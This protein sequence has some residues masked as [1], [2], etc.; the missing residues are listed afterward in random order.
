MYRDRLRRDEIEDSENTYL[1]EVLDKS[2]KST[3][4]GSE[5]FE[6]RQASAAAK[7]LRDMHIDDWLTGGNKLS[8]VKTMLQEDLE[9]INNGSFEFKE[10]TFTGD[11]KGE[12]RVLGIAWD[13]ETYT[14]H[15]GQNTCVSFQFLLRQN[16]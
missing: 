9:I 14:L 2:T 8:E 6:L 13:P 16:R 15:Y 7:L 3:G 11:T 12:M 10:A 1:L 5:V 4:L